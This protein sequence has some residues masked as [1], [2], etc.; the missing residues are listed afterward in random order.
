MKPRL[1]QIRHAGQQTLAVIALLLFSLLNLRPA[2]AGE[3]FLSSSGNGQWQVNATGLSNVHALDLELRYDPQRLS[4]LIVT[5][6]AGLTGA[7]SAINDKIPGTIRLSAASM[8]PLAPGGILLSLQSSKPGMELRVS[9]FS[10]KTVDGEGRVVATTIRQ[11]LPAMNPGSETLADNPTEKATEPTSSSRVTSRR[12]GT[13]GGTIPHLAE[14]PPPRPS[15]PT[16]ESLP[17]P[18][19]TIAAATTNATTALPASSGPEKRFHSQEEIVLAIDR[20]PQPWT[21]AAIKDIFLK[22]ATASQV[23]QE[24][25]VARA[26]GKSKIRL[27]LPK[28]LSQ[29]IPSVGVQGCILGAIADAGDQGW[30][31]ELVT[32]TDIWPAKALLLGEG[33][34]IQFPVV[35]VPILAITPPASDNATIPS[36]D[37]NDDGN[38]TALDA[39]LYV[40]NLLTQQELQPRHN[41]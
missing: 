23:R 30:E 11:E 10:V 27:Y 37:Y 4:G 29:K 14:E 15:P 7:M 34:L 3:I 9:R 36:V 25:P 2:S 16:R 5:T 21:V 31:V 12:T 28:T 35:I 18:A 40:G 13:S 22:P 41:N 17:T 39:Y 26:D 32:R 1:F 33:D 8:Q 20:L 24:P 38:I 6:G 19:P